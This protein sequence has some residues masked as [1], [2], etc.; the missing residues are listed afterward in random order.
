M[1]NQ[2][3]ECY[4]CKEIHLFSNDYYTVEKIGQGVYKCSKCGSRGNMVIYDSGEYQHCRAC[5]EFIGL[6][7]NSTTELVC[8]KCGQIHR[9]DDL[10]RWQCMYCRSINAYFMRSCQTCK[11]GKQDESVEYKRRQAFEAEPHEVQTL[12][13]VAKNTQRYASEFGCIVG[14]FVAGSL[15][16]V[17][18]VGILKALQCVSIGCSYQDCQQYLAPLLGGWACG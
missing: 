14:L 18:L 2:A 6:V 10:R 8:K 5:G 12:I 13:N 15:L 4:R 1:N 11:V 7:G 16:L 9:Y 17:A 3:K